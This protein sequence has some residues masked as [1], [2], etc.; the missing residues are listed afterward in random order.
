ML[1]LSRVNQWLRLNAKELKKYDS[2]RQPGGFETCSDA[3]CCLCKHRINMDIFKNPKTGRT[4]QILGNSSCRTDNCIYR[5][6]CTVYSKQYIG[7]T[8]RFPPQNNQ[9][10]TFNDK[11]PKIK[12]HI[13]FSG[14][15]LK[16]IA[17]V[18]FD[19]SPHLTDAKRK[20]KEIFLMQPHIIKTGRHKQ[21]N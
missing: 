2:E 9:Q 10:T 14:H 17:V 13:I 8:T 21:A 6:S 4:Y 1:T 5:I 16:D 12:K 18:D 20:S 15:K 7:D 3:T 19:H 11:D